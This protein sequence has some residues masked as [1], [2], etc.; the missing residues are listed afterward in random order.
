MMTAFVQKR[1]ETRWRAFLE[2]EWEILVGEEAFETVPTHI[3]AKDLVYEHIL[4]T[5][6]TA[7][8]MLSCPTATFL[9]CLLNYMYRHEQDYWA[10]EPTIFMCTHACGCT[11]HA[12]TDAGE[13]FHNRKL[14]PAKWNTIWKRVGIA[15][16]SDES[17]FAVR[18]WTD[19]PH[20]VFAHVDHVGSNA[21]KELAELL[22][23]EDE[24]ENSTTSKKKDI[25]PYLLDYYGAKYKKYDD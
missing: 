7:G 21:S 12:A 14:P 4:P 10:V 16:W 25:D 8:Y 5:L 1:R 17:D 22:Y 11:T 18:F 13:H 24:E 19:L 2:T 23:V 6:N 9:N 3:W 15:H 20:I